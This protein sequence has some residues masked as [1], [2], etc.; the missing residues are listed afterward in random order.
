MP[1]L[2]APAQHA[3]SYSSFTSAIALPFATSALWV[4]NG[5]SAAT[6]QVTMLDGAVVSIPVAANF[7]GILPLRVKAI[8]T[9]TTVSGVVALAS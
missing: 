4:S 7:A 6:L 2:T 1:D 9:S 8:G 3:I 5:A